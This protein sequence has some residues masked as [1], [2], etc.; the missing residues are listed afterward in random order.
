M[1]GVFLD[2][3]YPTGDWACAN[4]VYNVATLWS[5]V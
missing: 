2:E 4:A 3:L 1:R 5:F